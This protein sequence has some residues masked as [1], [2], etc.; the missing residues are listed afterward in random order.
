MKTLFA[1][2]EPFAALGPLEYHAVSNKSMI[3]LAKYR[4]FPVR[5]PCLSLELAP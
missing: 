3:Y 1:A 5:F 2:L 4:P